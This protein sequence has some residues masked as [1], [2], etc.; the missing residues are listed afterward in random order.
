VPVT[1]APEVARMRFSG[2]I[3]LADDQDQL[4]RRVAG[5]IGVAARRSGGGWLLTVQAG[6]IPGP[7][8]PPP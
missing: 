5:L 1:A 3:V 2:V 4:F 6:E 7:A 8:S